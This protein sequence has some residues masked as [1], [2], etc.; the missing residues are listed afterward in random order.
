MFIAQLFSTI[1]FPLSSLSCLCSA[2]F[3]C[4]RIQIYVKI[5]SFAS[6]LYRIFDRDESIT[7]IKTLSNLF[8][9]KHYCLPFH[10]RFVRFTVSFLFFIFRIFSFIV[11]C[12]SFTVSFFIFASRHK[13]ISLQKS[14][15]SCVFRLSFQSS[16]FCCFRVF[17]LR[18]KK[19]LIIKIARGCEALE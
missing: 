3:S 14:F 12:Q 1:N 2:A 11:P 19:I 7:F 8:V 18:C 16:H 6:A 10:S 13:I 15:N 4:L 9:P 5:E 17:S